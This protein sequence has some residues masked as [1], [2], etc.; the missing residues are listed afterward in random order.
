MQVLSLCDIDPCVV[1]FDNTMYPVNESAGVV[2][3]CVNLMCPESHTNMVR[4]EVSRDDNRTPYPL[5]SEFII[6]KTK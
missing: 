6:V 2:S 1:G 3:V 4:V 5:A